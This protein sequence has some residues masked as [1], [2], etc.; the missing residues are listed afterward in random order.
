MNDKYSEFAEDSEEPS[1][2][3]LDPNE[4]KLARRIRIQRRLEALTKKTGPEDEEIVEKTSIEKQIFAS[5]EVLEKLSVEG[6]EVVSCVKVAND[7]R[8]LQRRREE[9]KIRRELL[10]TLEEDEQECLKRY[11]EINAKWSNI[12]ASKDPLDIHAEMEAQNAK[13]LE[14]MERKD[15]VIAQL[16]QELENADLKFVNDQKNQNED[17]DLL[18]NR[19]DNQMNIM[20]KAYRRELSLIND[21]I[22]SE[23]KV[24]LHH[25]TEKWE[26]LYKKLQEDS[27]AGLDRR[28]EIMREYEEEMK[29]VI[30][31]HQE[32]FRTQKIS[33]ELEIQKLRQEVQNTKALCF[34]NIEKLDYSYAVLKQ[35]EDENAIVKNQ[36]KRRINK[37]QDVINNLKKN[38]AELEENTR[39]EIQRLT[40]Q[41]IKAHK[42]ILDLVEKSNHFTSVNDKKYMQIWDMNAKNANELLDKILNIDKIIYEQALGL[43]W[44]PPEKTLLEK[45][46]LP[47]Y[48]SVM[49][50]IEEENRM[51]DEKKAICKSYKLANT[52]EEINLE[53]RLLNHIIKQIADCCVY[54]IENKLLEL[55]LPYTAKD[56]LVIRLDNVFQA[57]NIKSE[58][59]LGFLL[60]FFLPYAYCPT[61]SKD[62]SKSICETPSPP[63]MD[64]EQLDICG[65][66]E[67]FTDDEAKLIADVREAICDEKP[68][69]PSVIS[70]S[71]QS[72]LTETLLPIA[73]RTS[74]SF[75]SI[76]D[77]V[78][79]DDQ[80]QR[81]L[82]CDKGHLLE[83]ETMFVT[84]ALREFVERYHFVKWKEPRAFQEKLIEKK[85]VVSRNMTIQDVTNFWKRYTEI[86]P[87]KKERLWDGLLI[88]LKKYHKVLKERH[89]LN[90][91]MESLRRQNAELRRLLKTYIIQP[92]D[93][94][95]SQDDTQSVCG[96]I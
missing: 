91:E 70:S 61:C 93:V 81:R 6:D 15:A 76:S 53:R 2:T 14:I 87:A 27:L 11:K 37:L 56:Q 86:F 26:A 3:S 13:C 43:E 88:G 46:D 65:V 57:L 62:I 41:V 72:S 35:R 78:K 16:R 67:E 44:D 79:D 24:L 22:E 10:K 94:E 31:E 17:I 32:E 34:M 55:L 4:R 73:E 74:T 51:A 36:Q 18:I 9:Q 5:F 1:I 25:I 66:A 83:I 82:L 92:E 39:L 47:S 38:Y 59:E 19:M 69:S 75:A 8:E 12:L 89:Q 80:M 40:D 30:I 77:I 95:S 48:C 84:K 33:F 85:T 58:E 60:N 68:S 54:L 71:S 23:R 7:A 52:I 28:K 45:E 64:V 96:N 50:T 49:C 90:V 20:A 42:N 63:K 29:R 21:V